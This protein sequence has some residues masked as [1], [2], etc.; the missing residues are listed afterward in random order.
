MTVADQVTTVAFR[1]GWA[2]VKRVPER[3]AYGIFQ[4]LADRTYAGNG[5]DVQRLRANY[6]AVRPELDQAAL[7]DLVRAGVRSY[8][9]YWC[10]AF[11][12]PAMTP[13]EVMA[14]VRIEGDGPVRAELAAGRP[15]LCFLGHLGNWDLAGAWGTLDLGPVVTVAERLKP[16]AVF[17]EFLAYRQSLGMTILPLT[18]GADVFPALV[19]GLGSPVVMPLLADRDLTHTGMPVTLCG[20]PSRAAI[21]PATLAVRTGAALFPVSIVY[22]PAADLPGG[23]RTVVT[24]HEPAAD[25]GRGGTRARVQTMTQACVDVLGQAILAH[26]QDWHMMQRVFV[27]LDP[28]GAAASIGAGTLAGGTPAAGS[29]AAGRGP[30]VRSDDAAMSPVGEGS[31]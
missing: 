7:E 8:L 3:V 26:T 11:R 19:D 30:Q 28:D 17:Q 22:E 15:V 5:R 23:W 9:R 31:A 29:P 16:E 1:A 10:E 27:D 2:V 18:G 25:P 20:H 4:F 21:G 13:A 12:L 6:A 14:R 24:F